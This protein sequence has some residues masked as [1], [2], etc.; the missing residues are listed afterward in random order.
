MKRETGV[1]AVV[2]LVVASAVFA[3]VAPASVA[4]A[5]TADRFV[6]MTSTTTPDQPTTD[7]E[8]TFTM[9]FHSAAESAASTT[10]EEIEVRDGSGSDADLLASNQ[11]VA[12]DSPRL[13][14]G[15]TVTQDLGLSLEESGTHE[16][17]V[18]V[19]FGTG[20][21]RVTTTYRTNVTVYQPNPGLQ[22][23]AAPTTAG[24]D[25]EVTV[26]VANGLPGSVRDV[27]LSLS[28]ADVDFDD[29]SR[30]ASS[31]ASDE[32]R[33]F[34]FTGTPSS[35]G[36]H[37]VEATLSYTTAEGTRRTVTRTLSLRFREPE[38]ADDIGFSAD[39]APALAG[40]D[41]TLNLTLTNGLDRAI[42]QLEVRVES[43][44]ATV[45]ESRKVA[46]SFESGTQRTFRFPVSRETAG[47]EDVMV[48][49]SFTT[50]DGVEGTV[51][52]ALTT[53]F[54][55]PTNPGEV[56]LTGVNAVQSGGEVELSATAS[57]VG[58]TGVSS[59]IVS[60]GDADGVESADYFVGD[61]EA[62]DFS[63]FTLSP[64]VTGN[65]SSL[66]VTVTYVVDGVE[67]STTTEVSVER[68]VVRQPGDGGGGTLPIVVGAIAI[69][70]VVGGVLVY[71]RR[72]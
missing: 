23:S 14:A 72:G 60:V 26:D 57:N 58:A 54:E 3:G 51:T 10:I 40:A 36:T 47:T 65:V 13:P 32:T 11:Y 46:T 69:V 16:L 31:I 37:E 6:T 55:E 25:T 18:T 35:L 17:F 43:E 53:T 48:T 20:L 70:L 56:R 9:R 5:A 41:T 2:L 22:A 21:E 28:A 29:G 59:V 19:T 30:V 63:S 15:E 49:L 39:V 4:G 62:G 12:T 68:Q 33:A 71:R 38:F 27:D 61:I 1:S 44:G 42:R 45:K 64:A 7:G 67:R 50:V 24:E 52:E 66:P 34:T 8:F